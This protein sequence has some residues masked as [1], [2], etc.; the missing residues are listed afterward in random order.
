MKEK[1]T[2]G[3]L[4]Y[5]LYNIGISLVIF[6][7]YYSSFYR[8]LDGF[9]RKES[10]TIFCLLYVF[11]LVFGI[12]INAENRRNKLSIAVNNII[13]I[14]VIT[15]CFYYK[16]LKY[17]VW[18]LL[19]LSLILSSKYI[20]YVAKRKIKVC[21]PKIKRKIILRRIK[22][23]FLYSRTVTA[24][25]FSIILVGLIFI[26]IIIP[27]FVPLIDGVKSINP[28]D[29]IYSDWKIEA[30]YEDIDILLTEELWRDTS[31][32]DKNRILQT[33]C[34]I[35]ANFLGLN[36][37][38]NLSISNSNDVDGSYI[39]ETHTI[40]ICQIEEKTGEELLSTI[41][42]ESYHAMQHRAVEVYEQLDYEF[43]KLYY[44]YDAFIYKEEFE[45][46]SNSQTDESDELFEYYF[47]RCEVDAR[48]YA[49]S[50]LQY[51]YSCINEI[52]NG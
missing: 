52:T 3:E 17:F 47:Q 44:F 26:N 6:Y 16:E 36:H 35:E 50:K 30:H 29:E 51:Y 2:I 34:N 38:L 43:Q 1:N 25:V 46:Y 13:P 24:F 48:N 7:I 27:I 15:A 14:E 4:K 8:T 12:M 21:T 9:T 42:H 31:L 19:C 28:D 23:C 39:K 5:Y 32:V 33:I 10:S 18:I 49:D 22:A 41:L 45:N 40:K 37:E 11:L 20:L